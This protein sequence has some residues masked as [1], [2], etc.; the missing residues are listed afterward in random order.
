[1]LS[2]WARRSESFDMKWYSPYFMFTE[3]SLMLLRLYL[4]TMV[5]IVIVFQSTI[6][7]PFSLTS[8]SAFFMSFKGMA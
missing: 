1:M 7:S 5:F 8:I 3:V 2:I 6:P 4:F